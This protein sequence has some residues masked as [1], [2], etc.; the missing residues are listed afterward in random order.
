M[1]TS[2]KNYRAWSD[3]PAI[4]A[5]GIVSGLLTVIGLVLSVCEF[6]IFSTSPPITK[7]ADFDEIRS[8]IKV[9]ASIVISSP[10]TVSFSN[11][12]RCGEG[13]KASIP[14]LLADAAPRHQTLGRTVAP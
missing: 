12:I 2:S 10:E 14:Q 11:A 7:T 13:I 9:L 5:I 1:K 3:H 8:Q 6:R 4:T